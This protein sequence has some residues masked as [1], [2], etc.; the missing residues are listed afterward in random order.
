LGLLGLDAVLLA[1]PEILF[2]IA[3]ILS[4]L[5]GLNFTHSFHNFNLSKRIAVYSPIFS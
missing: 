3:L 2:T 5:S 4:F 1:I